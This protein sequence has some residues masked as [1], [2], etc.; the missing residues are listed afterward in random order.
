MKQEQTDLD[1]IL[2]ALSVS[3]IQKEQ[4]DDMYEHVGAANELEQTIRGL[5]DLIKSNASI[6]EEAKRLVETT[7][8]PEFLEAYSNIGKSQSEA[9]KN[10]VKLLIEKEKNDIIKQT[11]EKE[12]AI[13]DKLAEHTINKG[14]I[15]L[16]SGSTL[17][18]TNVIM[19]GSR[20]EMFEMLLKIQEKEQIK[21]IQAETETI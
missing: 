3:N 7:G 1:D 13:K 21:V 20:E 17:N 2:G 16:P 15:S 8:E 4:N 11:K 19:N 10:K 12:I 14:A 9:F 18:Q 6:L 5:N